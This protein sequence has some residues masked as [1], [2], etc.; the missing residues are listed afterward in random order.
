[1]T[2]DTEYR[3]GGRNTQKNPGLD[4]MGLCFLAYAKS[5]NEQWCDMNKYSVIPSNL[6]EKGTLGDKLDLESYNI[7]KENIS[8]LKKGDVLYFLVNINFCSNSKD[9][10]KNKPIAK[11]NNENFWSYHMLLYSGEGNVVHASPWD[12][13]VVEEPLENF[14][15]MFYFIATRR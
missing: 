8:K 12:G 10:Q 9:T 4:C 1:S 13:K 5:F 7:T 11:I 14:K 15:N 3:W 2:L 6:I